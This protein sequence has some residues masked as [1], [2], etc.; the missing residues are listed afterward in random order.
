MRDQLGTDNLIVMH[1]NRDGT[2][3]D[4]VYYLRPLVGGK[5]AG[6]AKADLGRLQFG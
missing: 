2:T 4:M 1:A 6:T 5:G 3:S